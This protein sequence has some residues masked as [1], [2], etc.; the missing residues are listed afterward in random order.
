MKILFLL[1][2]LF[3][4]LL[5]SCN[6]SIKEEPEFKDSNN[7]SAGNV[8]ESMIA[9]SLPPFSDGIFPCSECHKDIKTNTKRRTLVDMHDDIDAMF[10]HDKENRWCLDC[11]DTEYRD[12]LKMAS[13]KR[14][15]LKNHINYVVN[16]M[17]IN[18]AIG[19]WVFMVKELANGMEKKHICC[20]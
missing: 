1:S 18:I 16:V 15:D 11:H 4:A 7:N 17:V 19:K 10:N 8:K 20:V 12:S 14:L 3:T 6:S 2:T 13:G 9:V 5:I